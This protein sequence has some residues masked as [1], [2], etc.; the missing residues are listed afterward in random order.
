MEKDPELDQAISNALSLQEDYPDLYL[1]PS[2]KNINDSI[3]IPK[4]PLETEIQKPLNDPNRLQ[5][6]LVELYS[7]LGIPQEPPITRPFNVWR[8]QSTPSIVTQ[9]DLL[10]RQPPNGIKSKI[11]LY[12]Y[13]YILMD[14]SLETQNSPYENVFSYWTTPFM[15]STACLF[16]SGMLPKEEMGISKR[17]KE[18]KEDQ[19]PST[20]I[21]NRRKRT[22]YNRQQTLFLQEQFD[23][24]PY[25]DYVSRCC[26]A[27]VTGIPEPRIQVIIFIHNLF[28]MLSSIHSATP[29]H[30]PCV[31]LQFSLIHFNGA[32]LQY[33]TQPV[34]K[35]AVFFLILSL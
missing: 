30:R 27:Q 31:V 3:T 15:L 20:S 25:P 32:D 22:L 6:T 21:Q 34:K 28:Q 11:F 5:D 16:F 10:T 9:D 8:D 26:F 1:P 19:V 23:F 33:Q 13:F 2:D 18:E 35:A 29:V 24:N 12:I 7:I 14:P 4:I 17:V